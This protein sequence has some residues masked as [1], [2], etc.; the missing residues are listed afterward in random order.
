M[1]EK[2]ISALVITVLLPISVKAAELKADV[3][4]KKIAYGETVE[5]RLSYDGSDLQ[6]IQPDLSVLQKDFAVYSTS[7]SMNTSIINGNMSQKKEW[8]ITLLPANEGNVTIPAISA[9]NYTSNPISIE[10]LSAEEAVKTQNNANNKNNVAQVAGFSANIELENNN[11]YI[12][13]EIL[14]TLTVKDNRNLQFESLPYF[15]NNDDW[16]IKSIGRP[17]RTQNDGWQTTTFVYALSPQKSGKLEL[18]SATIKGYYVTY[19][20]SGHRN[21]ENGLLQFFDVDMSGMFGVKKPVMLRTKPQIVN[22]KPIPSEYK[23]TWWVPADVLIAT[24][25]WVDENP[26]FKVGETVARE[27]TITASGVTENKLPEIEFKDNSLW[28]QYPD[29]PQYSSTVHENKII[30]QEIVRVVYIPQKS[31]KLTLPEI[32]IPWFNVKTQKTETAIIPSQEVEVENNVTYQN[33][34]QAQEKTNLPV[35][36]N[37]ETVS[38]APK[39]NAENTKTDNKLMIFAILIAFFSGLLISFLLFGRKEKKQ[40]T[41]KKS[42]YLKTAEKAMYVGDYRALRDALLH[43]G[44]EV[45]SH[46]KINNLKDLSDIIKDEELA[47]QLDVL[48]AILYGKTT[49]KF[50]MKVVADILKKSDKSK[51][52][53]VE[54]PLPNLYK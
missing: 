44:Q 7:S 6:D 40:L 29:K 35:E 22:I 13:Q 23:S 42:D 33:L 49:Q 8:I 32:I 25:E 30:S 15:E 39:T 41:V 2:V 24:A 34:S 50:D 31:G 51:Q 3:S 17:Q 1:L 27:I 43:W 36:N 52:K 28:K 47:K 45:Y 14:A 26:K 4:N 9:G 5:L 12:E 19:E 10:V 16:I 18:P 48:N 11:P 53:S 20:S 54:Q 38:V 37:K 21:L 46:A